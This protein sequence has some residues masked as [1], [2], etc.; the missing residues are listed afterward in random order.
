MVD[1]YNLIPIL[2]YDS[3]LKRHI[4]IGNLLLDPRTQHKRNTK[5]EG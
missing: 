1:L 5:L 4:M 3:N 2:Q